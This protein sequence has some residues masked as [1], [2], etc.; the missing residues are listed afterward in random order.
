MV[1]HFSNKFVAF[2]LT[3]L[4]SSCMVRAFP[5]DNPGRFHQSVVESRALAEAQ[6]V[7]VAE[8]KPLTDDLFPSC[9][10]IET[11]TPPD[12]HCLGAYHKFLREFPDQHRLYIFRKIYIPLRL[13]PNVALP[14]SWIEGSCE[15][16]L[17]LLRPEPYA[18]SNVNDLKRPVEILL[19]KCV[20]DEKNSAGGDVWN[21]FAGPGNPPF[22]DW[23]FEFRRI[24]DI[25]ALQGGN[26]NTN[27]TLLGGSTH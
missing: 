25:V 20:Y 5:K 13:Y 12:F 6:N 27:S 15:F 14:K 8:L 18:L 19:D 3:V 21:E 24:D 10:P 23:I 9:F 4:M 16:A 2:Y 1:H 26:T 7:T 11:P 17:D 22:N